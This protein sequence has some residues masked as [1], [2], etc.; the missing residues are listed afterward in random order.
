[1]N[2]LD[3]RTFSVAEARRSLDAREITA[4]ELTRA[5]LD[6]ISLVEGR[7]HALLA[8]TGERALEDAARADEELSAGVSKPLLGIPIVLK[9]IFAITSSVFFGHPGQGLLPDFY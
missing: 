5:L 4:T 9:D 3:P 1:M 2:L 7:L 6:R 8:V